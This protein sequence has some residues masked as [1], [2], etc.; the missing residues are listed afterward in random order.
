MKKKK[1]RK[2]KGSLVLLIIPPVARKA[3]KTGRK[4]ISKTRKRRTR[5]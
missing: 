5:K 3:A 2:S 4:V 1:T